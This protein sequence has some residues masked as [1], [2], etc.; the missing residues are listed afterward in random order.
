MEE[1]TQDFLTETTVLNTSAGTIESF[2]NE[3]G[4]KLSISHP[5]GANIYFADNVTSSFSPNNNQVLIK[6]YSYKTV[7]RD[8]MTFVNGTKEIRTNGDIITLSGSSEILAS[9][10]SNLH[11][12]FFEAVSPV[13]LFDEQEQTNLSELPLSAY[14]KNTVYNKPTGP[15]IVCPDLLDGSAKDNQNGTTMSDFE[16]KMMKTADSKSQVLT[17]SQNQLYSNESNNFSNLNSLYK[18]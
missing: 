14:P 7:E 12:R 18:I 5:S 10:E 1:N 16:N 3:G 2:A 15:V 13:V 17:E 8:E 9:S 11:D 6:G 4:K